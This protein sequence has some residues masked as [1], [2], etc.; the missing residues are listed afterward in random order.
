VIGPGPTAST[1][2]GVIVGS[3]GNGGT[4]NYTGSV[5]YNNVVQR[6]AFGGFDLENGANHFSVHD[7]IFDANCTVGSERP[8]VKFEGGQ[9][10]GDD[11]A[12]NEVYNNLFSGTN[13][14]AIRLA[15]VSTK[16]AHNKIYNN[17]LV[18]GYL[19]GIE[20]DGSAGIENNEIRNNIIYDADNTKAVDCSP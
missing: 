10:G 13:G 19:A 11:C 18:N 1:P 7:N 16:V 3:H 12:Y 9:T 17:T 2:Y 15:S 6:N 8:A 14:Y 4:A 5:F 20:C